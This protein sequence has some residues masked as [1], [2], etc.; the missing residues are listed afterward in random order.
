M[1]R[2]YRLGEITSSAAE[3]PWAIFAP[4]GRQ[5]IPYL[6]YIVESAQIRIGD[7]ESSACNVSAG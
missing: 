7:S 1:R 6:A 3:S 2:P 4:A 5:R